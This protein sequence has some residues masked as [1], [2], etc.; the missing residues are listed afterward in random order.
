[1]NKEIGNHIRIL[2]QKKGLSQQNM[3]DELGITVSSY[4]KME[5][6]EIDLKLTRLNQIANALQV[7]VS[8]VLGEKEFSTVNDSKISYSDKSNESILATLEFLLQKVS[9]LEKEVYSLKKKKD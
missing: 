5:R 1:V 4:S 3:A 6:G 7:S 8:E 2:R 9:Y